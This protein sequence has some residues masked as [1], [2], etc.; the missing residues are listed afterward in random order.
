MLLPVDVRH[1]LFLGASGGC[2]PIILLLLA[3]I[4]IGEFAFEEGRFILW[5]HEKCKGVLKSVFLGEVCAIWL[6]AIV[7]ALL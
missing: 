6:L 1:I 5:V 4:S 3:E 7:E 2:L